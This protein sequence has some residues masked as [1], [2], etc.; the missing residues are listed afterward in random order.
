LVPTVAG[1]RPTH[2]VAHAGIAG[3]AVA[4][5]ALAYL[6]INSH[7]QDVSRI[8]AAAAWSVFVLPL[9]LLG[10][11][12]RSPWKIHNNVRREHNAQLKRIE[13]GHQQVIDSVAGEHSKTRSQLQTVETSLGTK[14]QNL[15][16]ELQTE[17][18]Q[19]A[20]PNI[21]IRIKGGHFKTTV[22]HLGYGYGGADPVY[23]RTVCVSMLVSFTN[24]RPRRVTLD[25]Y[26]LIVELSDGEVIRATGY[27][28]GDPLESK[29]L[30]EQ[31]KGFPGAKRL[32][33]DLPLSNGLSETRIATFFVDVQVGKDDDFQDTS[34]FIVSVTD[35]IGTC[36]IYRRD[37]ASW[38][39]FSASPGLFLEA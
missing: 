9:Y 20:E 5:F 10:F 34:A 8:E 23:Y 29:A 17:R 11:A 1:L 33:R 31:H 18:D 7:E 14:I 12:I 38:A 26:E 35:S 15:Q 30:G 37:P 24:T 39:S 21:L 13:R 25:S 36:H 32:E 3:G 6:G 28:A 16:Q 2:E 19:N 22:E 4:V 27:F